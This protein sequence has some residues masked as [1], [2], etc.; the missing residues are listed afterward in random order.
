[1]AYQKCTE[2][3]Q[4]KGGMKLSIKWKDSKQME[5]EGKQNWLYS[6]MTD[7]VSNQN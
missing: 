2:M 6:Y 1:V 3:Y 4:D 5:A 7:Q